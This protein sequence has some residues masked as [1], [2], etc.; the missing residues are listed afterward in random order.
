MFPNLLPRGSENDLGRGGK[1]RSS[2]LGIWADKEVTHFLPE[3]AP[4]FLN[5]FVW[6]GWGRVGKA[7]A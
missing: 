6:L 3:A 1:S 5:C 4:A 2:I 7:L